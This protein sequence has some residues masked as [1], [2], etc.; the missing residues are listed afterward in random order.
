MG[1]KRVVFGN[2][3]NQPLK[4]GSIPDGGES[5]VFGNRFNNSV[6]PRG[7]IPTSCK[8]IVFGE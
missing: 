5:I 3:I 1:V 2:K 4:I 7:I 6:T 8:S